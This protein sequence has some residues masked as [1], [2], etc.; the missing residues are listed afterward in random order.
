MQL[1]LRDFYFFDYSAAIVLLQTT[2]CS[3]TG[4]TIS[5]A[6]LEEAT[7]RVK[8][9]GLTDSITLIFCDYRDCMGQYDAVLSCEMIE[10]VGQEHLPAY[11]QALGRLLKPGRSAVIQVSH[12]TPAIMGQRSQL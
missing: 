1:V 4:L 8:A 10:A 9:A 7:C 12:C 2:G 11:F 6:Q 3:W 5:K